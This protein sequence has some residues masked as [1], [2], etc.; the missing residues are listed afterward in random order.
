[1]RGEMI[2]LVIPVYNER[3]NILA[4][5]ESITDVL[6]GLAEPCEVLWVDDGSTDGT[7]EVLRELA[8]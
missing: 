1:M 3:E 2:S 5:C 4:L 7:D 8:A 6:I